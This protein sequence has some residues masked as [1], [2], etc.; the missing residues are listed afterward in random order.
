M[1]EMRAFLIFPRWVDRHAPIATA[2]V[3]GEAMSQPGNRMVDA[4][5]PDR[6]IH[7][8]GSEPAVIGSRWYSA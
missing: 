5:S 3:G 6:L 7:C 4:G 8:H 2:H 1:R